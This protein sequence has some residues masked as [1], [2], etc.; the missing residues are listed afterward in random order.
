MGPS[1]LELFFQTK[2]ME[3]CFLPTKVYRKSWT[4]FIPRPLNE[5]WNFF[6]RPQN[7][8]AVTPSDMHFEILTDLEG[9]EMYE[10]MLIN[11]RIRPLLNIPMKWCTEI[12]HIK[13]KE[14]FI[15]EQRFGPYA[16]WH[17][18][19][20]FKEL[21]G[22][23]EMRDLLHYAIPFGPLGRLANA[24]LVSRKVDQIFEFRKSAMGEIIEKIKL[25]SGTAKV[26]MTP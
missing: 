9:V 26:Q 1:T 19:H 24:V 16:M 23:V 10:G 15:D 5:V 12:T 11:Y 25:S 8:N 18:E 21:E 20:H 7:L 14:Y 6:S 13:E 17:H 4:T 22:G 3:G 2:C